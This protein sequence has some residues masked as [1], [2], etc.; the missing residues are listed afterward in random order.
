MLFNS[1][2]TFRQSILNPSS[3]RRRRR[4]DHRFN[5]AAEQLE[6]RALLSG[7][8]FFQ[9]FQGVDWTSAAVGGIGDHAGGVATINV[10]P[11]NGTISHAYLYWQGID[12]GITSA[13]STDGFYD[14]ETITFDGSMV[15]GTSLG[16]GHSATTTRIAKSEAFRADVTALVRSGTQTYNVANLASKAGHSA[17]GVS[18]VI[19]YQDGNAANDRDLYVL[20][21]NQ[22]NAGF[23]SDREWSATVAEF[24]G[25][26]GDV[27]AQLHVADGQVDGDATVRFASSTGG[28]IEIEDDMGLFDG[29]SVPSMG[30]SRVTGSALWDVHT[31]NLGSLATPGSQAISLNQLEGTLD[32]LSLVALLFDTSAS[33]PNTPPVASDLDLAG[34]EDHVISGSLPG[35]DADGDSLTYAIVTPPRQGSLNLNAETGHFTFAPPANFYGEV[36]FTYRVWDAGGSSSVATVSMSFAP[37]NDA[38]VVSPLQV[39]LEEDTSFDGHIVSHDVDDAV[40]SYLLID[41]PKNGSVHLASDGSFHF[42]PDANWNGEDSFTVSVSDGKADAVLIVVPVHVAAVNDAPLVTSSKLPVPINARSGDAIGVVRASDVDGDPLTYAIVGGDND[43]AFI[44]D[45]RTGIISIRDVMKLRQGGPRE[46]ILTVS[47]TDPSGAMGVATVVVTVQM[48]SVRISVGFRE[49]YDL[50]ERLTLG[51]ACDSRW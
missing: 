46:I 8:T 49:R 45:S 13:G 12:R 2:Q 19:I 32:S 51:A 33:P 40:L 14:N 26:S 21:G 7:M 39:I 31:F 43:G 34:F 48:P 6:S 23:N 17:N 18:L 29:T 25:G 4:V 1:L 30:R 28:S 24:V 38:P 15:V 5:V 41:G 36:S 22:V 47:A 16:I 9:K 11:V 37:V 35:F 44:I 3:K 20:N 50:A 42:T 10:G 27:R